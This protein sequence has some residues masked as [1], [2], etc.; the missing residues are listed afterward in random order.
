MNLPGPFLEAVNGIV[1]ILLIHVIAW[2][3]YDIVYVYRETASV[4]STYREA[5][6][7]IACAVAFG[8]ALIVRASIWWYRHLENDGLMTSQ[9]LQWTTLY[10]TIGVGVSIL[11]CACIIDRLSPNRFGRWPWATAILSSLVIGIW[12]AL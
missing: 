7:S 10:I 4:K 9:V 3:V 1:S 12:T 6:A 5:A 8:G 11:G 2:F